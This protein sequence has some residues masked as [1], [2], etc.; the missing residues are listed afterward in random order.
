MRTAAL[1]MATIAVTTLLSAVASARTYTFVALDS[2]GGLSPEVNA[3]DKHG[4]AVGASFLD[5]SG[6][7]GVHAVMWRDGQ[8]FDLGYAGFTSIAR[9]INKHG[10]I[11]VDGGRVASVWED[12]FVTPLGTLG[13][14]NKTWA[15]SINDAGQVAGGATVVAGGDVAHHAYV[16]DAGTMID[17]GELGGGYSEARDLNNSGV[18]VG[19]SYTPSFEL[20]AFVWDGAMVD[21]NPP[22]AR[23]SMARAVNDHGDVAGH[24]FDASFGFRAFLHPAGGTAVDLGTLGG[25]YSVANDVNDH[26]EVVGIA[27]LADGTYHPFITEDGTLVDLFTRVTLPEGWSAHYGEAIAI[28]DQ[29]VVAARGVYFGYSHAFLLVPVD[30]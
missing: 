5:P 25:T 12:G 2:L 6:S 24:Y 14:G 23:G 27:A 13:T 3:L 22:G 4:V 17:L 8:V 11:V 30:D 16:W 7:G 18:A 15:N 28:N 9:G 19:W 29:G 26:G 10:Q 21:V 20:H 1:G